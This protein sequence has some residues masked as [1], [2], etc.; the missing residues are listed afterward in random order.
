MHKL[1]TSKRPTSRTARR[2]G[3]T[4]VESAIVL[5]VLLLILFAM[6]DLG[7]ASV[8]YNALAEVSRR[9][10]R[11]T[12]LHGSLA[13]QA[14]G[15]WGPEAF[16]G[17]AGDDS[18]LVAAAAIATATMDD[19]EVNIRISWP[20]GDNSPRDRVR[21]EVDYRHQSLV[22]GLLPWGSFDLNSATTMHIVN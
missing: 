9:V 20:D 5:P 7:V 13:P 21:V 12:I 17:T 1:R 10:A 8:R 2:R 22:P 19:E 4:I 14:V 15:T 11:E 6:L 16:E 3:A 18:D